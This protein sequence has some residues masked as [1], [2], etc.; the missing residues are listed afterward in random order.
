MCAYLGMQALLQQ[1]MERAPP[2]RGAP[3]YAPPPESKRSV[4]RLVRS[5]AGAP[6]LAPVAPCTAL[7]SFAVCLVY[8]VIP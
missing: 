2:P 7:E 1:F 5:A 4:Y 6:S 3:V 8:Q